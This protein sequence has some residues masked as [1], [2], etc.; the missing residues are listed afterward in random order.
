MGETGLIVIELLPNLRDFPVCRMN[1]KRDTFQSVT[2][3]GKPARILS[4]TFTSR[5][6]NTLYL[7]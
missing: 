2:G 6:N 1:P 7:K 3:L 4:G 5:T